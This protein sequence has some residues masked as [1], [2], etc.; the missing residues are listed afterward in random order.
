VIWL[1]GIASAAGVLGLG[2]HVHR[3]GKRAPVFPERPLT[4]V[5]LGARVYPDGTPSP[6]LVDRV[7]V[8]MAL[9]REGRAS[10]LLFSGGTPDQRPTEAHTMARLASSLG[11]TDSQLLLEPASNSTFENA[12]RSSELLGAMGEAEIILI[13]CDFHVARALAHF[14]SAGL[15]VWPVPS[16]RSLTN[17]DRLRV[18]GKELIALLRRPW[19]LTKTSL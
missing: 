1:A 14:R 16:S 2:V 10:R 15:K 9:L 4:A 17:S 7:H 13:T 11:A 6:A 12:A 5:I 3:T 19:L 18:T 8:G